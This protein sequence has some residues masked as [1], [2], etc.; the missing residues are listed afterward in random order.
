MKNLLFIMPALPGGGAEKVLYDII[1]HIDKT[2]YNIDIL[3]IENSGIYIDKIEKLGIHIYSISNILNFP[4]P[5]KKNFISYIKYKTYQKI[6]KNKKKLS[7]KFPNHFIKLLKTK[8]YHAEISFLEGKTTVLLSKRKTTAKKIAWVHIDLEKHRTLPKELEKKTYENIDEIICVSNKSKQSVLNLY[9]NLKNKIK[10]IYNPIPK[11]DI[12]KLA[13]CNRILFPKN[14]INL[15]TVG[16]LTHQKGFD[17]L[18]KA[19]NKL[20]HEGLDYNL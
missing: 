18:L 14:K 16:R 12:L 1:K 13:N 4:K 10:T 2:K 11:E 3:L 6:Q 9:P 20:I 8:K 19:H 7:L 15:I 17:I 5:K